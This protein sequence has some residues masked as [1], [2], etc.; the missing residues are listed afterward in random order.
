MSR[1][2]L[3]KTMPMHH[4]MSWRNFIHICAVHVWDF[5]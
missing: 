1:A 4:I 3:L 5:Y 2:H